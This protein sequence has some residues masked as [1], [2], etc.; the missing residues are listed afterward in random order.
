M[1]PAISPLIIFAVF[2][3]T[4]SVF[5][6]V[7]QFVVKNRD[8]LYLPCFIGNGSTVV[9]SI[10]DIFSYY[11]TF[12]FCYF[13]LHSTLKCLNL[14]FTI[15]VLQTFYLLFPVS[16]YIAKEKLLNKIFLVLGHRHPHFMSN[17]KQEW[18][19]YQPCLIVFPCQS[20]Q[21]NPHMCKLVFPPYLCTFFMCRICRVVLQKSRFMHMQQLLI[22][23][24]RLHNYYFCLSACYCSLL[25]CSGTL[26]CPMLFS[27]LRCDPFV[28]LKVI[29]C[30]SFSL[31]VSVGAC[32]IQCSM[33]QFISPC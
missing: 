16:A 30:K 27:H 14:Y 23:V 6:F 18:N 10:M 8:V 33:L 25:L 26:I 5:Y 9:L 31:G 4:C 12:E 28:V 24:S 7:L 11:F 20:I 2:V 17:K 19:K 32:V 21:N 3:F 29:G 15:I 13:S 22:P 1:L